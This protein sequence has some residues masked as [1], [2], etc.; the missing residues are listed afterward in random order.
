M[1]PFN[2]DKSLS[3]RTLNSCFL[4]QMSSSEDLS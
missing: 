1:K 2:I 3:I 4:E